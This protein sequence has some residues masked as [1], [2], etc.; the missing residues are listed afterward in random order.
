M[1]ISKFL[2]LTFCFNL[3][4]FSLALIEQDILAFP[5][6]KVVLTNEK[7]S[8]SNKNV[9]VNTVYLFFS[10]MSLKNRIISQKVPTSISNTIVMTSSLGQP[11]SCTIPNVQVEQERIDRE[12]KEHAQEETEQ[13]IQATIDRGVAL[14]EP[15]S[16]SCIR[17]FANVSF[18]PFFFFFC[19]Q[20]T[21][22]M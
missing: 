13:D 5:R 2:F 16:K 9:E 17:F 4:S 22:Y 20:L 6:Y 19:S 7:I 3:C 11:F 21:P 12:K 1:S 8:Q 15:L 10:Y 18:P 14:L